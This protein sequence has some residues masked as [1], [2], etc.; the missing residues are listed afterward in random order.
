METHVESPILN[1]QRSRVELQFGRWVTVAFANVLMAGILS[2][3]V[4]ATPMGPREL[5][6]II[7]LI[8]LIALV[9]RTCRRGEPRLAAMILLLNI[10]IGCAVFAAATAAPGKTRDEVLDRPMALPG[11]GLTL[12]ELQQYLEISGRPID[13]VP[14]RISLILAEGEG[15]TEIRFPAEN[16]TLREFVTSLEAQSNLRARF[17]SCGNGHTILWGEDCCFGLHFKDRRR[18]Y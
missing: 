1:H 16:L 13:G 12:T 2:A 15:A 4:V 10:G 11:Q 3:V 9:R 14:I 17:S 7:W 5:A 18:P 6:A 8:A